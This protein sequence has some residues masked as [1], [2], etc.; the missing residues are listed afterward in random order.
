M[1]DKE[2]IAELETELSELR[3]MIDPAMT[4]DKMAARKVFI[5]LMREVP[6]DTVVLNTMSGNITAQSVIDDLMKD[7]NNEGTQFIADLLRVSR[8]L[9]LRQVKREQKPNKS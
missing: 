9:I 4:P 6:P 5:S 8:D 1:N 2:R 3:L 7:G